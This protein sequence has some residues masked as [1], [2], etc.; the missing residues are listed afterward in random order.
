MSQS[1]RQFDSRTSQGRRWFGALLVLLVVGGGCDRTSMTESTTA[2]DCDKSAG[3]YFDPKAKRCVTPATDGEA[4]ILDKYL[5]VRQLAERTSTS[6]EYQVNFAR[7]LSRDEFSSVFAD[8]DGAVFTMAKVYFPHVEGGT[9]ITQDLS[10]TSA[11]A[12]VVAAFDRALKEPQI[13][14][15]PVRY[16]LKEA[17]Q[18]QDYALWAARVRVSPKRMKSWWDAHWNDVRVI[19]PRVGEL[20]KVQFEYCPECKIP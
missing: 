11:S 19:Q 6:V 16:A 17:F 9:T 20:D 4:Y 5:Y 12:A 14:D 15:N 18:A 13:P 7:Y 3:N 8:L 10:A 2:L 1:L